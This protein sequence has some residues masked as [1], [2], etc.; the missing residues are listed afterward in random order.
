VAAQGRRF[1]RHSAPSDQ[2]FPPAQGAP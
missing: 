1:E 2:G